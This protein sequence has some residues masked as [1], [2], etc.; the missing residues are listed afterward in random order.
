MA[1]ELPRAQQYLRTVD[2]NT[3]QENIKP[4]RKITFRETIQF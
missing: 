2:I 4:S 3:T 1:G